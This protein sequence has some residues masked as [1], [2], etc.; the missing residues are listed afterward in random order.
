MNYF[1]DQLRQWNS[2]TAQEARKDAA[3]RRRVR[4]TFF[5]I[6]VACFWVNTAAH[7]IEMDTYVKLG[8]ER[9]DVDF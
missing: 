1:D 3:S 5:G 7:Q 4:N 2:P 9:N 8:K 6:G